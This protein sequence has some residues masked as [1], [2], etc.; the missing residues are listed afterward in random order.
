[1]GRICDWWGRRHAMRICEDKELGQ[2][3]PGEVGG[4]QKTTVF[5][6]YR[7][8]DHA[9]SREIQF[10]PQMA[11]SITGATSTGENGG[12]RWNNR[13]FCD[14]L[15]NYAVRI[16]PRTHCLSS[17]HTITWQTCS[18]QNHRGSGQWS[19]AHE[20]SEYA[21]TILIQLIIRALR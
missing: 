5:V 21:N 8:K 13:M 20:T 9:S 7:T 16:V 6:E 10:K 3:P 18:L 19:A 12:I 17:A 2:P 11:Q 14:E 1:M 4:S 15:I